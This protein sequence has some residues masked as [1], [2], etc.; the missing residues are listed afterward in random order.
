MDKNRLGFFKNRLL[1]EKEITMESIESIEKRNIDE[2]DISELSGYDN[3]PADIGTEVYM[4]EQDLGFKEKLDE[5]LYEI[6]QSLEDIEDGTYGICKGCEKEI[7]KERL[8]LIPYLKTCIDCPEYKAP[9][10]QEVVENVDFGRDDAYDRVAEFNVV[11]GDPSFSTGDNFGIE[12][13]D[14][15]D[16]NMEISKAI[17]ETDI[18]E[19]DIK[20]KEQADEFKKIDETEKEK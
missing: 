9:I 4:R 8:E 5:T 2:E 19:K 13:S 12:S 1:E 15:D 7:N 6:E 11:E 17:E 16:E 10:K 14:E 3:H 20:L 18:L